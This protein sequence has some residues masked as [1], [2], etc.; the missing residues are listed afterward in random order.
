MLSSSQFPAIPEIER[1]INFLKVVESKLKSVYGK[2][3]EDAF[4]SRV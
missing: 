3:F 4:G 2:K 1:H